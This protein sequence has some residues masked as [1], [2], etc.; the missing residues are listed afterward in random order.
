MPIE[1]TF[2]NLFFR[3]TVYYRGESFKPYIISG[4]IVEEFAY[5]ENTFQ[6]LPNHIMQA[7][8]EDAVIVYD[9]LDESFQITG[10]TRNQE[11]PTFPAGLYTRDTTVEIYYFQGTRLIKSIYKLVTLEEEPDNANFIGFLD[12]VA[13]AE[14]PIISFLSNLASTS[15]QFLNY[16]SYYAT[17]TEVSSEEVP[18]LNFERNQNETQSKLNESNQRGFPLLPIGLIGAGL[19]TGM[20]PLSFIGA[21]LLLIN[22][23]AKPP[24]V[25]E[26]VFNTGEVF[27]NEFIGE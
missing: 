9:N 7:I 22:R 21:G 20:T 23:K 15:S 11:S 13:N 12:A 17:W 18:L 16:P 4:E 19:V 8:E 10:V 14:I 6:G 25:E 1:A 27:I 5:G 3:D 26:E 2:E 24:I